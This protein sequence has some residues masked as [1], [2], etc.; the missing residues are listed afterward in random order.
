[1]S[2]WVSPNHF[3]IPALC[4]RFSD[5][6]FGTSKIRRQGTVEVRLFSGSGHCVV[7]TDRSFDAPASRTSGTDLRVRTTRP[8]LAQASGSLHLSLLLN[9]LYQTSFTV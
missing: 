3:Q 1:M 7:R 4:R 5:A 8:F 2:Q 9:S 6:G